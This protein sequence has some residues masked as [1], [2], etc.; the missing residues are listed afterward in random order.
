MDTS[1]I[2]LQ[3]TFFVSGYK[4]CGLLINGRIIVVNIVHHIV[5]AAVIH[6]QTFVNMASNKHEVAYAC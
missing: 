1:F 4:H 5:G 3:Q 6:S 2:T